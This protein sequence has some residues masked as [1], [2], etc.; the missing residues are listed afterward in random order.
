[1][2]MHNRHTRNKDPHPAL[3]LRGGGAWIVTVAC[4]CLL[5]GCE[6][7]DKPRKGS[8][9]NQAQTQDQ[10][11]PRTAKPEYAFVPG[12]EEQ[13]P[14]VAAFLRRFMETS[15]AG[16]Y[17]GYRRMVSRLADPESRSRFETILNAMQ[18]LTIESIEEVELPQVSG[19]AYRVV[20]R[21]EFLPHHKV[22]LR[23][24]DNSQVAILVFE[25]EG[26][27]RMAPAPAEHQPAADEAGSTSGPTTAPSYPWDADGD[28]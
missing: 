19:T 21:V 23:R 6:R 5:A 3:S 17:A 1:M 26:E 11:E 15:L 14:Q 20:S 7:G 22:T 28:Y 12:V 4:A 10:V 16:D 18:K 13:Y 2:H 24:G 25:E 9:G 27:L 8:S